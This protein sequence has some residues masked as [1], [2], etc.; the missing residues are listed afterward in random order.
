MPEDPPKEKHYHEPLT[1]PEEFL[2]G[3]AT[4]AHQVEGNN[5]H[6]DW[7]DWELKNQP[8]EKRSGKAD[9][10][11]N[12]Y[13]QDF[14]LAKDLSHNS[15][16]LSI[17]W[18]RIEPSEGE[19][20]IEAI[21]HYIKVLKELKSLNFTVM[22]TLWHFTLPKWIADKGGWE[23]PETAEYFSRFVEK[24]VPEI[25]EY[26]DL[27]V[28]IN[29]PTVYAFM[30]Y[31]K[32]VW[33]PQKKN[34]LWGA[35]KVNWN[36]ASAHKKAY[37]IIH[38]FIPAAK[39]GIAQNVASFSAFHKHSLMEVF[40]VWVLDNVYNQVFYRFS[41]AKNHDF[42]GLNYYFHD[43]ISFNGESRLPEFVD[44]SETKKE[45]SDMGWEIYPQGMFDVLMNF[46]DYH[47]PIYITENGLASTNDDRR[48]RFLIAYLQEIY[49]A[50]QS[51]AKVRG[52]F[53][54]S[55]IDNFEWA[56]GFNPR[57]GIVEVDYERLAK[58]SQQ[59][60]RSR[61]TGLSSGKSQSR[62]PRPS[63]YVYKDIIE[64]NG[65]PHTL[66]RFLGHTV[67]AEEVLAMDHN[68]PPELCPRKKS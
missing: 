24:I 19:F 33:P 56:D 38:H 47:L 10:Q 7:F 57:F 64:H 54:W 27:W 1:F 43:Y 29:E 58:E 44:V 28:T 66:L 65:I 34:S 15:H 39:V 3:A 36:L 12:L 8:P 31:L 26:V 20:D 2:W 22:L 55:L 42:L 59:D 23:N 61:T 17:E 4:S 21:L 13:K 32:G 45:V 18:A 6:S 11:Y 16:R 68:C 46:T 5:I 50:I 14:Q 63:A 48:C 25:K 41:N 62:T 49:H 51:G 52:Y 35:I 37:K 60:Q 40:A 67:K 30:A 9:D 53:H